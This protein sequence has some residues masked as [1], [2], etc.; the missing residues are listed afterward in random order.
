VAF[1]I[2]KMFKVLRGNDQIERTIWEIQVLGIHANKLR[3][4]V[5]ISRPPDGGLRNI[6][7]N[8]AF[9]NFSQMRGPV[10]SPAPNID[11]VFVNSELLHESINLK[12]ILEVAVREVRDDS[13]SP[14]VIAGAQKIGNAQGFVSY[15][16]HEDTGFHRGTPSMSEV[17][18][19]GTLGQ[20]WTMAQLG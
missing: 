15:F 8:D 3:G 11:H 12:M 16:V 6:N 5:A 9:G 7:P 2:V 18:K 19:A 4:G 10:S 1:L 14:R 13:L 17:E 20:A